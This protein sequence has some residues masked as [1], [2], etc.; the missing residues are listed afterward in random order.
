MR[1]RHHR[2]VSAKVARPLHSLEVPMACVLRGGRQKLTTLPVCSVDPF[3]VCEVSSFLCLLSV[4]PGAC[5]FSFSLSAFF[6]DQSVLYLFA[7]LGLKSKSRHGTP[8]PP[9]SQCPEPVSAHQRF[10]RA[11]CA[12][13][14][15]GTVYDR[16]LLVLLIE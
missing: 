9:A 15:D 5:C 4:M 7:L 16:T 10:M 11:R 14:S 2:G 3:P 13:T 1:I 12:R 6:F 8:A